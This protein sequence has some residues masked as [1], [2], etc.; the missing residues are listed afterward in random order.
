[1][2]MQ[3]ASDLL[4]SS[5]AGPGAEPSVSGACSSSSSSMGVLVIRDTLQTSAAFMVHTL[6]RRALQAGEKVRGTATPCTNPWRHSD[7]VP[8]GG[9]RVMQGVDEG[10]THAGAAAVC[11]LAVEYVP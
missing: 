8:T 9:G 7:N 1:M 6:L 3:A 10:A 2:Q 11:A 4:L 5:L